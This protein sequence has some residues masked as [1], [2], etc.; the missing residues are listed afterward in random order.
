MK[1][2]TLL[3]FAFSLAAEEPKKPV[4]KDDCYTFGEAP[5]RKEAVPCPADGKEAQAM[6]VEIASLKAQLAASQAALKLLQIQVQLEMQVCSAPELMSAK[7]A[8]IEAQ[9][10]AKPKPAK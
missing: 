10:A 8:A 6:H 5:Y 1:L 4:G 2:L 7:L 9:K 3:L